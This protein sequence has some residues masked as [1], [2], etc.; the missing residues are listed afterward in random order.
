VTPTDVQ[1]GGAA[2]GAAMCSWVVDPY[3]EVP[4]ELAPQHQNEGGLKQTKCRVYGKGHW[5][6]RKPDSCID[7]QPDVGSD[8][9]RQVV[10]E[11]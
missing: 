7:C 2:Q 9:R 5:T 11:S 6:N 4:A 8:P 10:N 3:A 1:D